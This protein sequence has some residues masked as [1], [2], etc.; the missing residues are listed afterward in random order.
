MTSREQRAAARGLRTASA[1]VAPRSN[2]P[3]LIQEIQSRLD[4]AV[5]IPRPPQYAETTARMTHALRACTRGGL[6]I[7]KIRFSLIS[8][9]N[10]KRYRI[11][12]ELVDTSVGQPAICVEESTMLAAWTNFQ[13]L[14]KETGE[15][16]TCGMIT[17]AED[18]KLRCQECELRSSLSE[19]LSVECCVCLEERCN[20][21][22]LRCGHQLCYGCAKLMLEKKCPQCRAHFT[23][24]QGLKENLEDDDP[25]EDDDNE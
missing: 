22:A 9:R 5:D 2:L 1:V 21:Y 17:Y 24:C 4:S 10:T 6:F 15:C 18:G 7:D 25:M 3:I 8:H 16:K 14:L 23:L 20:M 12:T 13:R 11:E 19:S